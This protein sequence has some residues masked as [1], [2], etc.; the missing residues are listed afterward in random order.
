MERLQV[1]YV[2]IFQCH[3]IEFRN[4]DQIV[5]ETIPELVKLKKEGLV[6]HI[7]ITGLPLPIFKN[8]LHRLQKGTVDLIL[9]Y[10]HNSL[11]DN[12][13]QEWVPYLKQQ[14][15]AII[16]ASPLSMGL[17]TPKGTAEWNPAPDHVKATCMAAARYAEEQGVSLPKLAL[18]YSLQSAAEAD[19][20]VTLVGMSSPE[21]V[22]SNVQ[23]AKETLGLVKSE[24]QSKE[25]AVMKKV[26]ELLEPVKNV[27]WPSGRP[28]NSEIH[29]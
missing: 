29:V 21:E 11:N 2:D 8:V 1:D 25:D 26:A 17:L 6:R 10:C 23:A 28:K 20:D 16:S 22:Q 13:L 5:E 18:K 7:G 15:V 9:A 12:S 4:L 3:D 27:T 19:V 14:E 24:M